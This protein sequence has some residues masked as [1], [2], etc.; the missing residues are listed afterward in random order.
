MLSLVDTVGQRRPT[1]HVVSSEEDRASVVL[2]D[3]NGGEG[4]IYL[5]REG[6]EFVVELEEPIKNVVTR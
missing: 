5:V 6:G 4:T 3:Q 1:I 2:R